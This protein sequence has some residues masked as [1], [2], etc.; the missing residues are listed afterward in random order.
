MPSRSAEQSKLTIP[1]GRVGSILGAHHLT[2]RKSNL[3]NVTVAAAV[4]AITAMI[5]DAAAEQCEQ[6]GMRT[7]QRDHIKNAIVSHT[8]LERMFRDACFTGVSATQYISPA[9][10][11]APQR[12]RKAKKLHK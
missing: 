4:E 3:V 1:P 11:P 7:V 12:K 2:R 6:T 10:M 5:L 9:V 8:G